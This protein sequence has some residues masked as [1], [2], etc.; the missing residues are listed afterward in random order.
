[1]KYKMSKENPIVT[2]VI[3]KDGTTKLGAYAKISE[4]DS[5]FTRDL[6]DGMNIV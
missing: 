4:A 2:K 6:M 1:M 5:P 3:I